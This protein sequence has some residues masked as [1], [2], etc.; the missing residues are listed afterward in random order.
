MNYD[1]IMGADDIVRFGTSLNDASSMSH[2]CGL[3][4]ENPSARGTANYYGCNDG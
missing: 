3:H 4:V 2:P 1:K